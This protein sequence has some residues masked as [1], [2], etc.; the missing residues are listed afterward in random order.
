MAKKLNK[1]HQV[2]RKTGNEPVL[3]VNIL[4]TLTLVPMVVGILMIGAWALDILFWEDAQ[5]QIVIGILFI[6][7]S[8]AVS[9]A[10]QKRWRLAVGWSLLAISDLIVLFW[11][12]V[13]VQIIAIGIGSVGL[14]II[15]SEFI[16]QWKKNK[17]S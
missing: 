17:K 15:I 8:F 1:K 9:N 7:I 16:L 3:W 14:L 13:T 4:L 11:L 2:K 12:N 5:A 10:L 6:L